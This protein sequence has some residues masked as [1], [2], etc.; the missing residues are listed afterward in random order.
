M[1]GAFRLELTFI[2]KYNP[3]KKTHLNFSHG[4]YKE[5]NI[6]DKPYKYIYKVYGSG[7]SE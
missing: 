3:K 5:G 7:M 4:L 2:W 1:A 6:Y